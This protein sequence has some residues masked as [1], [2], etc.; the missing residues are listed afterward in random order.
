[1]E[2]NE[3]VLPVVVAVLLL[4]T[5]TG[6]AVAGVFVVLFVHQ[7][8]TKSSNASAY[9]GEANRKSAFLYGSV[10]YL[11]LLLC[12]FLSL[13]I[14]ISCN[15]EPVQ[16]MQTASQQSGIESV[17][18]EVL[19]SEVDGI[20]LS[21]YEFPVS[22]HSAPAYEVQGSSRGHLIPIADDQLFLKRAS[23]ATISQPVLD[24]EV[25][26]CVY[27]CTLHVCMCVCASCVLVY[28]YVQV[29]ML[30]HTFMH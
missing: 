27:A 3:T 19:Y 30:V 1:M 8:R 10:H 16:T 17:Y 21:P 18:S 12:A 29:C 11:G 5:V 26:A 20:T 23:G 25:H 13:V 14:R 7:R 15:S 9:E 2:G 4:A 6:M 22:K 28:A 24:Q